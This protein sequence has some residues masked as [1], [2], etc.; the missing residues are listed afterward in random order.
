MGPNSS[1]TGDGKLIRVEGLA[2]TGKPTD[3][4]R[5]QWVEL[6]NVNSLLGGLLDAVSKQLDLTRWGHAPHHELG[7]FTMSQYSSS[8]LIDC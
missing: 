3:T 4:R 6:S 2:F 1:V 8:D 7:R 5:P